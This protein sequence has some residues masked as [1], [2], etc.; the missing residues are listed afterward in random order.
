MIKLEKV[1]KYY[2]K[3]RNNELHVI[4]ECN[5]ELP[6]TGMVCFLGPSGSGKTTLLN[7]IGGLDKF[8]S[9]KI[10]IDDI[11]IDKY[12]TKKWD[13]YRFKNLGYIFQNYNLLQDKSVFENLQQILRL[14]YLNKNDIETRIMYALEQVGIKDYANQ[15]VKYLS[16]GQQQRVSI[17]RALIKSPKII[18]ADEPTGNLDEKNTIQIMKIIKKISQK[19]LVLLVTHEKRLAD[20]FADRIIQI[21][22]G[23]I[24]SNTVNESKEVMTY[25]D[26][27][28]IYLKELTN[29]KLE[30]ENIDVNY[31]FDQK[32]DFTA[33]VYFANNTF[34]LDVKN[35]NVKLVNDVKE[36]KIVDDYRPSFDQQSIGLS[37]FNAGQLEEN[38]TPRLKTLDCV[39]EGYKYVKRVQKKQKVFFF[40]FFFTAILFAYLVASIYGVYI[41]NP[42]TFLTYDEHVV[43]VQKQSGYLGTPKF[44]VQY[45]SE[46]SNVQFVS[47]PHYLEKKKLSLRIS[48]FQRDPLYVHLKGSFV[49]SRL[50]NGNITFGRD[51]ENTS[52][53]VIDEWVA[54][55]ILGDKSINFYGVTSYQDLVDQKLYF[56]NEVDSVAKIVGIAKTNSFSVYINEAF[57]YLLIL[58]ESNSNSASKEMIV[59][60]IDESI[61]YLSA[62]VNLQYSSGS[63]FSIYNVG[64]QVTGAF[65]NSDTQIKAL[66]SSKSIITAGIARCTNQDFEVYSTN[67]AATGKWLEDKGFVYTDYYAEALASL[68]EKTD[69]IMKIQLPATIAILVLTLCFIYFM[70]RSNLINRI[71]DIGVYRCVG[72]RKKQ[73]IKLFFFEILM[74][75]AM[76]VLPGYLI[77]SIVIA[78]IASIPSPYIL[79]FFPW[80]LAFL[81][82]AV[83][84]GI[85]IL[86]GLI[87]INSLLKRTPSEII[88]KYD[89]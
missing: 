11:V 76:F 24:A 47:S 29:Q 74:L 23:V 65:R 73:I 20:F 82:I 79:L 77:A 48:D 12:D 56:M 46:K 8:D 78:N 4:N 26:S 81:G 63:Y 72:L 52:E 70:M 67:R 49:P 58:S 25:L 5:L 42:K 6:E 83:F 15:K 84:M 36:M 39:A 69:V 3:G 16:G 37:D 22:D 2:N 89:I 86:V 71:Y 18:I 54:D 87:P 41:P 14:T 40:G 66:M 35:A 62:I 7:V 19:C 9:G 51:I 28:N 85:F 1:N 32:R 13:N 75:G 59:Y 57:Y 31:F 17:A 45:L 55:L 44:E 80:W 64:Y 38:Y 43:S 60:Q 27:N 68:H 61:P 30:N 10:S 33:D 34:Y 88:F 50:R 21:Q 53:I